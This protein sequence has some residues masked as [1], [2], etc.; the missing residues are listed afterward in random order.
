MSLLPIRGSVDVS[1]NDRNSEEQLMK[2][3]KEERHLSGIE[4]KRLER[5]EKIISKM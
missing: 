5:F 2:K 3:D 1:Y 4:K